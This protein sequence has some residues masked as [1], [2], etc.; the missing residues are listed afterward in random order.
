MSF[1]RLHIARVLSLE[2]YYP[3]SGA[4]LEDNNY[5]PVRPARHYR[6]DDRGGA[7]IAMRQDKLRKR[8]MI[9]S[10]LFGP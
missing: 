2:K 1:W 7:P 10:S 5:H 8:A 4:I 3:S 9:P 6:N